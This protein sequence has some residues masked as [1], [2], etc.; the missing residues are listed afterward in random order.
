M[1]LS[2]PISSR[3]LLPSHITAVCHIHDLHAAADTEHRL[4]RRHAAFNH[5]DFKHVLLHAEMAHSSN[6]ILAI[7]VRSNIRA[8]GAEEAVDGIDILGNQLRVVGFRE[9]DRTASRHPNGFYV[10]AAD[11]IMTPGAHFSHKNAGNADDRFF[12][13]DWIPA[14]SP[15]WL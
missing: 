5:L 15:N 8:A 11:A 1:I 10:V 7:Q 6:R 4:F 14:L 13:H 2:A 3:I 9:N 12:V